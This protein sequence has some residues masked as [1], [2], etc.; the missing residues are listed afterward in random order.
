MTWHT[1]QVPLLSWKYSYNKIRNAAYQLGN[2]S[3]DATTEVKR[4]WAGLY[5]DGR[6][7][8]Y[9]LSSTVNPRARPDAE[10][11]ELIIVISRGSF[12]SP[13]FRRGT[14]EKGR[15]LLS[16]VFVPIPVFLYN[17]YSWMGFFLLLD[18]HVVGWL[19]GWHP[20]I[21]IF[22]QSSCIPWMNDLS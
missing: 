8:K 21:V 22:V 1:G 15:K 18:V 20:I 13:E 19:V 17:T 5:L 11:V 14:E 9:C 3:S 16:P 2:I 6:L 4:R 7:F 10:D 12:L